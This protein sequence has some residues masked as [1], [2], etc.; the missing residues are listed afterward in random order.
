VAR[1]A[2]ITLV[3]GLVPGNSDGLEIQFFTKPIT[4]TSRTD[5][6]ENGAR[7]LRRSDYATL[8]LFLDNDKKVWQVNLS[9]VVPGSTVART[10]A[11]RPEELPSSQTTGSMG[12]DCSS[13]ARAALP[14]QGKNG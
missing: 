14:K 12:S 2:F 4:E 7:E 1:G 9:Y 8:V 6:L 11:W 10:V 3:H 5:I 13:R